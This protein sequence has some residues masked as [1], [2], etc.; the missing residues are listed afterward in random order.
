MLINKKGEI[1]HI[2]YKICELDI[3][4]TELGDGAVVW[5]ICVGHLWDIWGRSCIVNPL[6]LPLL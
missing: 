3:C 2:L 5:D 4:G 6:Q 1:L